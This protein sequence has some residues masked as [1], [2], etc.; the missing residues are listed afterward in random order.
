MEPTTVLLRKQGIVQV[1][2][3][4]FGGQGVIMAGQ[5]LG[6]AVAVYE[7][8]NAVM[9][10]SY[11]PE[12]RGGACKAEIILADGEIAYPRVVAPDVVVALSQEAYR[13]VGVPRPAECLL[14][15]EEDL[16][17]LDADAE[18]SRRV[19]RV[20]ASRLAEQLGRR[21]VLNVV[22]LGFL[23][24]ATGIASPDALRS[25]I[26][27]SVPPGTQALNLRA[28]EAGYNHARGAAVQ[29]GRGEA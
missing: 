22:T 18:G 21:V 10:R 9:G 13:T 6:Q 26:S 12:S 4:G 23:C 14:I 16:V 20:P 24:G 25:A 3:S 7:G 1:V 19:L 5:I 17:H 11:G 27:A 29:E 28:F 8:R 15:A 2:I